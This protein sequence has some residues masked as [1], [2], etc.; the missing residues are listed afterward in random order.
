MNQVSVVQQ[1]YN[2]RL[3]AGRAGRSS[4]VIAS[5]KSFNNW[6]KATLIQRFASNTTNVLDLCC[7]KGGDLMKWKNANIQYLMALDIADLSVRQAE[8]RS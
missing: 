6:V 2:N 8:K 1:H 7:G 4:S 3:D 5:L